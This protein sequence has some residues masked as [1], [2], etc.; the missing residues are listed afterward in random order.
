MTDARPAD[1]ATQPTTPGSGNH[2]D[3][4]AEME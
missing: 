3:P 1:A 2:E 4:N